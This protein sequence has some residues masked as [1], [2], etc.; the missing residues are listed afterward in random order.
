MSDLYGDD[1]ND[2]K[3]LA[4]LHDAI[5]AAGT[6]LDTARSRPRW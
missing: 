6:L 3:S 4:T 2:E 5:D 1:R